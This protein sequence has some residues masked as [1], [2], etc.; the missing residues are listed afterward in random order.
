LELNQ[1]IE[2]SANLAKRND[3]GMLASIGDFLGQWMSEPV[4]LTA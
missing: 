4:R 2:F 1:Q 3:E